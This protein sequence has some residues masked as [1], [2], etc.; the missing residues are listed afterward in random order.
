MVA[1]HNERDRPIEH[2]A[3]VIAMHTR[4]AQP[5]YTDGRH[6]TALDSD[7]DRLTSWVGSHVISGWGGDHPVF[8]VDGHAHSLLHGNAFCGTPRR[9]PI[10]V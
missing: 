2:G 8:I 9:G 6:T 10:A 4:V 7:H 3:I 5:D 1:M